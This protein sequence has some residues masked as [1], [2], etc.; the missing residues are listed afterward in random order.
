MQIEDK[1]RKTTQA[2]T[3]SMPSNATTEIVRS[4]F[5]ITEKRIT[6]ELLSQ[7]EDEIVEKCR[8]NAIEPS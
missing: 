2:K 4:K 6:L 5:S 1:V 7:E 8:G 3:V